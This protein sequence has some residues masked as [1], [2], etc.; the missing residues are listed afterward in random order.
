MIKRDDNSR[1]RWFLPVI[2]GMLLVMAL[3]LASTA[4]AADT[5]DQEGFAN[6]K[7]K[8]S[9]DYKYKL[10]IYSGMEGTINREGVTNGGKLLTDFYYP[11]DKKW[12]KSGDSFAI[13]IDDIVITNN[14]YYVRGFRIA[15]HD[16]D[17]TTGDTRMNFDTL[18]QDATYEVAYGIRG[19]MVAYTVEF[20]DESGVE[21]APSKTYYG[22]P[23]DKPVVAYTYV[24]G[25]IP[26]A[27]NLAK[28]LSKN[29]SD[30]VF[31]FVYSEGQDEGRTVTRTRTVTDPAAP[32]TTANPAGTAVP[33]RAAANAGNTA[34]AGDNGTA[35]IG[36]GDTPLAGPQQFA[37]LDDGD[38]P[39]AEPDEGGSHLPLMI[40]IG[41]GA[42]LLIA[43]IAWLLMR[44]R[45]EEDE[46]EAE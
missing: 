24:E 4:F 8:A 41:A 38:T 20:V 25:Y 26:N 29:E 7:N 37:D 36:D 9:V 39:M 31:R 17:E 5:V 40:G 43:L 6:S 3:G 33:G 19:D 18:D 23:G 14:K 13:D 30:N 27:Y 12:E 34:N 2:L 16:N 44:R 22:M 10:E 15:G 32:G 21:L 11:N 28:T 42:L 46:A 1:N 35:N 45:Q